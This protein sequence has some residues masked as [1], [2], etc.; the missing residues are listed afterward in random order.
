ML[1][2]AKFIKMKEPKNKIL[3]SFSGGE[4]SA[5]MLQ[6]VLSNYPNNDIKVIFGNTGEE[7]EE[8]LKFVK[9]CQDF[10]KVDVVWLEYERLSFNVVDF[11]TAYRSHNKEEIKNKWKNH[12]FRKYISHFGIPN[13][14]SISCSRELKE[15]TRNRYLK[16]VDWK[17]R[18]HTKAIGI[19]AD[20]I[21]RM[22]KL[23]Y[24]LVHLGITK[25][26]INNFW[27]KM[28]FRL[29]LKGYE[30]NCKTCWK[31][32]FR[33][34][35]TI[36]RENKHHFD[37]FK[38]M[39]KE[40]EMFVKPERKHSIKPPI[41]FFRQNK[42]VDDVFEIAKDKSVKNADDDSLNINYQTSLFHDGTELDLSNGCV[43][44]CEVW[45]E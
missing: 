25:P 39:E 15:Y 17:P 30:G 11:K 5:F 36:A 41:R 20:E 21:D 35:A 29:E 9:N 34:L 22:G 4:T 28:P 1:C 13:M 37:F 6:W 23:W 16:S 45:T 32:S 40:F 44:S 27:D 14:Q 33:K 3:L 19:R 38:Q 12:P 8:T 31:K 10:F 42:T 26:M 43:E 18:E 2:V 24:P 7:N